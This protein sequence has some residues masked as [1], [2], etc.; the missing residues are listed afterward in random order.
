M[1]WQA[2]SNRSQ[3]SKTLLNQTLLARSL[4]MISHTWKCRPLDPL[5]SAELTQNRSLL[6][7]PFRRMTLVYQW[8]LWTSVWSHYPFCT[9]LPVFINSCWL[10]FRPVHL[11]AAVHETTIHLYQTSLFSRICLQIELSIFVWLCVVE[12]WLRITHTWGL[13]IC[14]IGC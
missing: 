5:Q 8:P 3:L 11:F 1:T 4:H 9:G 14:L 2:L 6:I 13:Y 7:T 12:T 10:F